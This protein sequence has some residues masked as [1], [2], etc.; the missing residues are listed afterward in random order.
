MTRQH[1]QTRATLRAI[2]R[3]TAL[4]CVLCAPLA[5][6]SSVKAGSSTLIGDLHEVSSG[7]GLVLVMSLQRG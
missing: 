4:A 3:M 1:F 6:I 2:C 5:A 7:A